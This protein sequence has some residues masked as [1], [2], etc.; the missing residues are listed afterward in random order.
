MDGLQIGMD[1]M[2]ALDA[3]L[4][5]SLVC[6]LFTADLDEAPLSGDVDHLIS[7]LHASPI[8]TGVDT[9]PR[10]AK[11]LRVQQQTAI[12]HELFELLHD[13]LCPVIVEEVGGPMDA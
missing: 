5:H 6:D 4:L 11:L 8:L 13:E 10:Q 3:N 2:E 1:I 12:V 9:S 7:P